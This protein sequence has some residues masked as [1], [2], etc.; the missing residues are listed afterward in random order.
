M[1]KD[2]AAS[3][4]SIIDCLLHQY[5]LKVSAL[6]YLPLGAD[7]N[8]SVYKAQTEDNRFYFIKLKRDY[9]HTMSL[10]ITKLLHE[11]GIQ[12]VILPIKTIHGL[13]THSIDEH[14][15]IV[16][17]YIE[18]EDGFRRKLTDD[19]WMT[20]GKAL[21]R[22][23]GVEVPASLRNQ[24]RQETYSNRW[25]QM[26]KTFLILDEPPSEHAIGLNLIEFMKKNE[27]IIKRL[28]DQADELGGIS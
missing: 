13:Q 10:A 3:N 11:A 16:Y 18:G 19:Q 12:Q 15:L 5:H 21:R 24:I 8:A 6:R 2:Q 4:Q 23:H 20:L 22:V 26:V 27:A 25:R 17:P 9:D 14:T 28:I 1:L 7:V